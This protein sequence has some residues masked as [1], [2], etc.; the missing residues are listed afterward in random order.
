MT[1]PQDTF[2]AV[3]VLAMAFR[4]I[5]LAHSVFAMPFAILGAFLAT[6]AIRPAETEAHAGSG[7]GLFAGQLGLVVACMVAAR[8]WAMLVNRIADR[9]FDAANPRTARRAV[10]SG[11]LAPRHA[12]AVAVGAA[13]IF[14]ACCA[15]FYLLDRNPWPAILGVPT[16]A[17]IGFYSFTKRFTWAAHL[18]LGGALAASPLAA[19]IA[20]RP[21]ALT[22]TPALWALAAMVLFWVAGFDVLYSLQDLEFDRSAS[23]RSIPA[24]VGARRAKWLSRAMHAA[25]VGCLL[26]A[27]RLEPRLGVVFLAGAIGVAALLAFEHFHLHTRG[28]E[29]LPVSFGL[30]NGVVS[31]TLGVVGCIDLVGGA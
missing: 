19:A 7:W 22:D 16:L 8:T 1:Q 20:V 25:A 3:S 14:L 12:A 26:G 4:D 23:L 18:F 5:K 30:V 9:R 28:I 6:D 15:A 29:G 24:R 21:A 17:W 27:W 31:C 13:A 2:R 11:R 10:A